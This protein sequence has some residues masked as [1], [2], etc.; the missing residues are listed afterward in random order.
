MMLVAVFGT[1]GKLVGIALVVTQLASSGG[2]F[3]MEL[4]PQWIQAV[5]GCL[6]MTYVLRSLK[7]VIS[8]GNGDIYWSNLG[9]VSVYLIG[10]AAVMLIAY[11]FRSSKEAP[12]SAA[13]AH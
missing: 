1:L 11:L 6:P 12:L 7:A 10:F 13:A 9:V 8:T 2:T 3:P 4:A 5:G